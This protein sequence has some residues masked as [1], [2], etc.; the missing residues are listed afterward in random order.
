[1]SKEELDQA[2]GAGLGSTDLGSAGVR[3]AD[4]DPDFDHTWSLLRDTAEVHAARGE[5]APVVADIIATLTADPLGDED[6]TTR[7]TE[8]L[9]SP[10]VRSA[11]EARARIQADL[12]NEVRTR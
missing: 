8:A 11:R 3:S 7:L 2:P 12:Q 1:M 9:E 6:T 5:L 10:R 4:P